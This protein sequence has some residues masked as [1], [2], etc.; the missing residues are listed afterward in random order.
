MNDQDWENICQRCGECCFEKIID[1]DGTIYHTQIP[2]RYL[3]IVTRECKVYHKRF[4][5]GEECVRLTPE[6]VRDAVWLTEGCA[7]V[8]WLRKQPA[9]APARPVKKKR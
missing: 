4:D 8:H 1:A 2:C 5:T 6:V 9:P 3:D 7:Y